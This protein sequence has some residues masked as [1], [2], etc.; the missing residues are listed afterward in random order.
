MQTVSKTDWGWV[1]ISLSHKVYVSFFPLFSLRPSWPSFTGLYFRLLLRMH[2][3]A[4]GWAW[5]TGKC[6]VS[7][8]FLRFWWGAPF[9]S[10]SN[11][12]AGRLNRQRR[13]TAI[14]FDWSFCAEGCGW[15]PTVSHTWPPTAS[16]LRKTAWNVVD[17]KLLPHRS[18]HKFGL[19]MRNW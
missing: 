1:T 12:G 6:L 7:S 5:G 15:Q 18:W 16:A 9:A 11:S 2:L 8:A 19:S 3:R 10:S 17:V 4:A 14:C 13:W